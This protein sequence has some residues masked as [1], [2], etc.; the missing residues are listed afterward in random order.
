[1]TLKELARIEQAQL[2]V[3]DLPALRSIQ[4]ALTKALLPEQ[5]PKLDPQVKRR[6]YHQQVRVNMACVEAATPGRI[7]A[8]RKVVYK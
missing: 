6:L 2:E 8:I 1:M 3:M 4:S 7:R 5:L